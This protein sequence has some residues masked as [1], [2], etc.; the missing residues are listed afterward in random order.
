MPRGSKKSCRSRPRDAS[1]FGNSLKPLL[2]IGVMCEATFVKTKR[3]CMIEP[4]AV[5]QARRVLDMKHF[6]EKNELDES[7]GHVISVKRLAYG[8]R[9]VDSI[10]MSEDVPGSSL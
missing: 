4:P 5:Y 2:G 9:V 8:Y 3:A 7:L 6:V 10:V 1:L